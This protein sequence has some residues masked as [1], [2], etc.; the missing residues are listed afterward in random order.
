MNPDHI[1]WAG[2][3][4]G[5]VIP[6]EHAL[7]RALLLY[8]H[9]HFLDRGSFSLNGRYG[10]IGM[11][12]PL[13]QWQSRFQSDGIAV[14]FHQPFA[15]RLS[16][17]L[18]DSVGSD[19]QN[20]LFTKTFASR[21]LNDTSFSKLFVADDAQVNHFSSRSKS[22]GHEIKRAMQR[23]AWEKVEFSLDRLVQSDGSNFNDPSSHESLELTMLFHACEASFNLNSMF[24][25]TAIAEAVPWTD[26]AAYHELVKV[27]YRSAQEVGL[28]PPDAS[29]KL[30]ALVHTILDDIIG[31]Q[32]IDAVALSD[33]VA[34]RKRHEHELLTFRNYV[35]ALGYEIESEP[36]SP[37]LDAELHKLVSM[38]VMPKA[39]EYRET[40]TRSWEDL[41]GGLVKGVG[42][43]AIATLIGL[44]L[45]ST[46]F[47]T[48]ATVGSAG[49]IISWLAT[50]VTDLL[51]QQ[52][53]NRRN[54]L[55]FLLRLP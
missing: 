18:R 9:L 51:V 19:L 52:R 42:K 45:Q 49:A 40:L 43:S 50:P 8:D 37:K 3:Y 38:E 1:H 10:T 35:A 33:V 30:D 27:K 4:Y 44:V 36:W 14:S 5:G 54:A 6:E 31:T 20:K 26:S 47:H 41:F 34:F 16:G 53:R 55:S 28:V 25:A 2:L 32:R 17:P 29:I 22:Y 13:R 7:K 15:G 12:S 48:L 11:G 46:S 23:I 39:L 21:F 24:A